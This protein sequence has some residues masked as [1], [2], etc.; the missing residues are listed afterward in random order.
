[1]DIIR[2]QPIFREQCI[3]LFESNLPQFFAPEEKSLF[4]DW[5]DQTTEEYFVVKDQDTVVACGGIFFDE[6]T[7]EAGLSWGMVH[8]ARHGQGI[9]RTFTAHRLALIRSKYPDAVIRIETSQHTKAFYEKLGFVTVNVIKDG[10]AKGLD[11]YAMSC[12]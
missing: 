1:M 9:G 11:L 3:A 7:R 2:Y 6:K 10:F 5:L 4:I 12:R 8:A